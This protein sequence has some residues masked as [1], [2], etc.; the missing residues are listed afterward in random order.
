MPVYNAGSYLADA[1]ES[2]LCQTFKDFEFIVIDDG[3]TDGS[4]A[5]L[6]RFAKHDVRVR[7]ISRE[8]RGITQTR[9]EALRLAR[10][11]LVAVMD[12][13]DRSLPD[14][15]AKQVDFMESF[16]DCVAVGARV[17]LIDPDGAPIRE[18]SCEQTHEQIDTAHMRGLGGAISHPAAMMRRA[19]VVS[20]GGYREQFD[21]AEDFD[22][23][24]R[25]AEHGRVANLPDVLL[26][27]RQHLGSVGYSGRQKQRRAALLALREAHVRRGLVA[28]KIDSESVSPVPSASDHH[29][30]WA[31]W[32][33]R[34][35]NIMTARKH[36]FAAVRHAPFSS[37]AWR[38]VF[39]AVRGR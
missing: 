20:V 11:E 6:Q 16:P 1:V 21:T 27:Y 26:W 12:A 14:R 5:V 32:A 18:M 8:N 34:A 38:A 2:I 31:W 28:P 33:L 3:S 13:D 37:R 35:G 10:G 7:L 39:C 25:L 9:N 15:L 24:L 23:F 29:R 22:L 30:K 36:A 4:L 19:V 17:L